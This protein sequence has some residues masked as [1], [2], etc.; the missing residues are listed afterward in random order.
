VFDFLRENTAIGFLHGVY[1]V[2]EDPARKTRLRLSTG[3][4][5]LRNPNRAS[6]FV[7]TKHSA[8]T[9]RDVRFRTTQWELVLNARNADSSKQERC[10]SELCSRYWFPLYKF[11]LFTGLSHEDAQDLTQSFFLYLLRKESL[12][13]VDRA[14][15]R[16]RSFLL[17]S[18]RNHLSTNRQYASA[19]KRGGGKPSVDLDADDAGERHY[20]E[21]AD[22]LTAET[23][24]DANWAQLLIER[25]TLRLGEEYGQ[26]GKSH[27][28]GRLQCF[29]EIGS[30]PDAK[31]YEEAGR[32]LG[33]SGNGAKTLVFRMRQR[34]AALMRQEVGQT[35]SN[36][37]D[38]DAEI[39]ALYSALRS[40]EGRLRDE[41]RTR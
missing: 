35:L 25:V 33:M 18:F 1:T 40:T 8:G 41:L 15:G 36:P 11:A 22:H 23:F 2:A 5:R 27:Q 26:R 34:F 7:K 12:Q 3:L 16:F 13:Q 39:H 38:T 19:A 21:L 29:L 17:A 9:G 31:S 37:R 20:V 10:L 6:V 24:F 28:F 4:N 30:E 14:K 32:A